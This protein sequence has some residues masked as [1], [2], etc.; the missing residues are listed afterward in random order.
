MGPLLFKKLVDEL[1]ELRVDGVIRVSM[2]HYNT[3][4]LHDPIYRCIPNYVVTLRSQC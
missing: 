4:E 1:L 3:G 2:V